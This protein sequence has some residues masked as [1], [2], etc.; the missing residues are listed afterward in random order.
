ML[1]QTFSS[2]EER[3]KGVKITRTR[4]EKHRIN[5]GKAADEWEIQRQVCGGSHIDFALH[6]LAVHRAYC[7]DLLTGVKSAQGPQQD[8][9]S[10]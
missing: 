9:G 8:G 6:L 1:R 5:L 10:K 3:T 7:S 4:Y 2:Q